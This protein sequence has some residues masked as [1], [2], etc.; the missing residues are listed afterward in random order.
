MLGHGIGLAAAEIEVKR[1]LDDTVAQVPHIVRAAWWVRNVAPRSSRRQPGVGL[2]LTGAGT[3]YAGA[4][5]AGKVPAL[6]SAQMF[7]VTAW[8]GLSAT[9]TGT[10]PLAPVPTQRTVAPAR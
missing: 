5:A 8:P 10:P 6:T 9:A 1:V 3:G 7:E 2:S 4:R